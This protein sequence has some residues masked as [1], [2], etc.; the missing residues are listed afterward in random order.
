MEKFTAT[1][2]PSDVIIVYNYVVLSTEPAP[3]TVI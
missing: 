2:I 3:K 1:G